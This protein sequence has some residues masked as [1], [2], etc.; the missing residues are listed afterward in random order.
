MMDL[1]K[2]EA[3]LRQEI[4]KLDA[5]Y[6]KRKEKRVIR[7]FLVLSGVVYLA[8]SAFGAMNGIVEYLCGL[9]VAP[10]VAGIIMYGSMLVLLYMMTGGTEE[11]KIIARLEGELLAT[12]R[13]NKKDEL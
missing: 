9:V 4:S 8:A 1:S 5:L 2:E 7:T 12:M 11:I 13:F 10:F 3:R 6:E